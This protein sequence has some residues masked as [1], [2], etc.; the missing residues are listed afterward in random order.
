MSA[1]GAIWRTDFGTKLPFSACAGAW[2]SDIV[3]SL[4]DSN[5]DT[6]YFRSSV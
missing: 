5:F 2:G 3:R 6:D 1:N 4:S